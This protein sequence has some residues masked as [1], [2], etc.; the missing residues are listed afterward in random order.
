LGI[1][2][3]AGHLRFAHN[4]G[5]NGFSTALA[6]YP[7]DRLAIVLLDNISS[8]NA[9]LMMMRLADVALGRSVILPS[10]RKEVAADPKMLDRYIGRYQLEHG[11]VPTITRE[12]DHLFSQA[13]Q[14]QKIEM[15]AQANGDFFTKTVDSQVTFVTQGDTAASALVLH[16][17][18]PDMTGKRLP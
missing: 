14:Q 1:S 16:R 10:E 6:W 15:F 4:G 7:G 17:G 11:P 12:G 2:D 3:D 5:I 9:N 8:G 18:G 13:D